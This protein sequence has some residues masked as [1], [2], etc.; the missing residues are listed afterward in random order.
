MALKFTAIEKKMYDLLMDGEQ[1]EDKELHGLL[2][3]DL[4][5]IQN[6]RAHISR[7]RDKIEVKGL[8]VVCRWAGGRSYYRMV[9]YLASP[10]N[11]YK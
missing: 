6:V 11:G 3:D 4:A 10:N 2:V 9:R 7:L 5:P 8:D 1:H